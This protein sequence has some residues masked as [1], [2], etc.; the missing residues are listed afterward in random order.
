MRREIITKLYYKKYAWAIKLHCYDKNVVNKITNLVEGNRDVKL[1]VRWLRGDRYNISI[2]TNNVQDFDNLKS[3]ATGNYD[4][5]EE[6]KNAEHLE[7]LMNGGNYHVI[8]RHGLWYNKHPWKIY[9][10]RTMITQD[11]V[12]TK[13][14]N[15][16]PELN[17]HEWKLSGLRT[18]SQSI[19]SGLE[20]YEWIKTQFMP[21]YSR[22]EYMFRGGYHVNENKT[23]DR[24]DKNSPPILKHTVRSVNFDHGDTQI[25]FVRDRE[26]LMHVQMSVPELISKIIEA[27]TG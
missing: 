21:N 20:S 17:E 6:P 22:G 14:A 9:F 3:L 15:C 19:R 26:T 23:W 2:F 16:F 24:T 1:L 12:N 11:Q 5:I 27:L 25:L 7:L 18:H 10:K 13:L 8:W 4:F